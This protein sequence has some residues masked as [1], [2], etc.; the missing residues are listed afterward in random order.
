MIAENVLRIKKRIEEIC[1]KLNKDAAQI[2][3]V[4]VSKGR[5]VLEIEEAINA[6]LT[7]IGENKVQ[8]AFVK[9]NQ[10]FG[11]SQKPI[12]D[13]LKPIR[14]HMVG[15]LQTN[16]VKEAVRMFELI[17]S[18]DSARLAAEINKEAK[19]LNKIQ[20]ILVEVNIAKDPDKFGLSPQQ[21]QETIKEM[22]YFKNIE[23][24]GLMTIAPVVDNPEETRSFFR[25]LRELRD[26]LKPITHNL[27]PILSMGM[28]DDYEIAI[29]EGSNMIRLGRAIFEQRG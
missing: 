5:T 11:V 29:E 21:V 23:V 4:A 24:K 8:E 26:N 27:L 14:Y 6:G 20:D 15:H 19:K 10:L 3:I 12:T 1:A 7:N 9:Y 2:S 22:S 25:L 17:H 18:V 28:S 13:N 16:K